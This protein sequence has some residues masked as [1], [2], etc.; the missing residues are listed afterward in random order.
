MA[1]FLQAHVAGANGEPAGRGV[2]RPETLE[3]MRRPH[4]YMFG[5]EI[6]G[7]GTML[8]APNNAGGFVIGHEGGTA[9]AINTSARI[10]PATGDGIVLLETGHPRLAANIA[11]EWVAWNTGH[12]SFIMILADAQRALPVLLGGWL[13]IAA[14]AII[15]AGLVIGRRRR[16][17]SNSAVP[18]R[19]VTDRARF[20]GTP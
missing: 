10:D 14:G 4:V 18:N 15:V 20:E 12:E 17:A 1:R 5:G 2:L 11:N 6:F 7:L 3:E 13:A 9:P 8:Y 16:L 19:A